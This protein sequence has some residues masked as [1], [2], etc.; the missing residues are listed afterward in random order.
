[1]TVIHVLDLFDI[2]PRSPH[3][4]S[5]YSFVFSRAIVL[6]S[7]KQHRGLLGLHV[8]DVGAVFLPVF[9]LAMH[10]AVR[11]PLTEAG[12]AD[13]LTQSALDAV[14][15]PHGHAQSQPSGGHAQGQAARRCDGRAADVTQWKAAVL[16]RA[17]GHGARHARAAPEPVAT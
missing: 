2:Q 9:E 8:D 5:F 17:P 4:S 7:E 12:S 13:V 14:S 11:A 15:V 10:L 3:S 6:V 1:M 16:S